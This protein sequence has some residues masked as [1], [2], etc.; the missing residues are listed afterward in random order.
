M[1]ADLSGDALDL[2]KAAHM[3]HVEATLL[4]GVQDPSFTA[5]KQNAEYAGFKKRPSWFSS[6]PRCCYLADP[7]V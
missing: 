1:D 6:H 7:L 3:E 4:A 2:S 5:I